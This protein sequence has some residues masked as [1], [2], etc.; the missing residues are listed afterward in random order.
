MQSKK[1]NEVSIKMGRASVRKL[2]SIFGLLAVFTFLI[3]FSFFAFLSPDFNVIHDVVSTLGAHNE[4]YAVWWNVIG[5]GI[6][7]VL[8]ALFGL[9]YGRAMDDN[10]L[11]G[12]LTF[13]GVAFIGGSIPAYL[14]SLDIVQTKIHFV[15]IT[16][17]MAF[18]CFG[19]ARLTSKPF[20]TR[21]VKMATY[22]CLL[23]IGLAFITYLSEDASI[24][25]FQRLFFGGIFLWIIVVSLESFIRQD[26][27]NVIDV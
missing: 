15:M 14:G 2:S 9:T 12:C 23:F 8:L 18:W 25:I 11:A 19:L 3:S 4:P 17:S 6:V 22:I 21:K 27:D 7:G 26:I 13:F 16:L 10:V 5:F 1:S 24:A 20:V